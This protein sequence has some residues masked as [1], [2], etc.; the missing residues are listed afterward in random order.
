MDAKILRVHLDDL[1]DAHRRM[2][3]SPALKD[4]MAIVRTLRTMV[5]AEDRCSIITCPRGSTV[6]HVCHRGAAGELTIEVDAPRPLN[7]YAQRVC[8]EHGMLLTD[9]WNKGRIL[10]DGI[11][12]FLALATAPRV[13]DLTW[14]PDR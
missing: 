11:R 14:E 9:R 4:A 6:G 10:F 5:D 3:S 1:D 2:P 7:G 8:V 13:T 12:H